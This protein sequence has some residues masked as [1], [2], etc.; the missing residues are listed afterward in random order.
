MISIYD[1]YNCDYSLYFVNISKRI[2]QYAG[3]CICWNILATAVAEKE[4]DT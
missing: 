4:I 1:M 2:L 3:T